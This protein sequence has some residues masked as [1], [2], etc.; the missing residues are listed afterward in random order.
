MTSFTEHTRSHYDHHA[1]HTLSKHERAK[2][3]AAPLKT[4]HN[5]I[6]R[7]LLANFAH[8]APQLLDI[9]CGRGGDLAKWDAAG[10]RQVI[11]I[12]I[13]PK[14]IEEAHRR[15]EQGRFRTQCEFRVSSTLAAL[16][17]TISD[18]SCDVVTCMF[19]LQYF[20]SSDAAIRHVLSNVSRVLKPGGIFMGTVPDGCRIV[21]RHGPILN[22]QP[23]WSGPRR[24]SGSAYL[25][26]IVDTVTDGGSLEYAVDEAHLRTLA[27]SYGLHAVDVYR[28]VSLNACL[29]NALVPEKLFKHFKP[30][31]QGEFAD[32]S[33]LFATFVFKKSL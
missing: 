33:R 30:P 16:P 11:G 3:P 25:C 32:A 1:T 7:L 22:V 21:P 26:T 15:Y 13:S 28:D 19:A 9:A 27:A 20:W 12:D 18:A 17:W 24:V 5:T 31:Y 8:K 14:E 2:G 6:K 23:L 10:V 4:F 29:E